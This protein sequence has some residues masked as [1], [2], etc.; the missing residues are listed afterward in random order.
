MKSRYVW[1][2]ETDWREFAAILAEV[3]PTLRYHDLPSWQEAHR[4]EPPDV[5]TR[6]FLFESRNIFSGG[7]IIGAFDPDWQP[8]YRREERSDQP[9]LSSWVP[10][11]RI[12]NPA[13]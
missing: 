6:K 9:E 4:P 10:S 2:T 7:D 1:L 5:T 12:K 11:R 13:F 3:F 8:E